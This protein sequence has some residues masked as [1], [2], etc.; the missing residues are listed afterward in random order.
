MQHSN[1]KVMVCVTRQKT[2][3]RLIRSG[4]QM[5]DSLGWEL[6]VAHVV[7]NHECVMGNPDES[8]ALEFLFSIANEYDAQMCMMRA[9]EP[10][11]ALAKCAKQNDAGVIIMGASPQAAGSIIDQIKAKLP[12]VSVVVLDT[13]DVKDK[14]A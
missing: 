14:I 3:E 13:H 5:A 4:A 7:K 12:G 10:F 1:R 8:A 6:C 9:D 2:C 11:E